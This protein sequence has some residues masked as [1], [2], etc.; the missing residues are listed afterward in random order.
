M[1]LLRA[2]ILS[3]QKEQ[4]L[5]VTSICQG[6]L[7]L[8]NSCVSFVKHDDKGLSVRHVASE[9]TMAQTNFSLLSQETMW[10]VHC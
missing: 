5:L 1:V 2:L 9:M 4:V 3:F 10:P 6:L 8:Y 7:A